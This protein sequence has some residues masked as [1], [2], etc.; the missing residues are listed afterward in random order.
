M[1]YAAYVKLPD[2]REIM[3][4]ETVRKSKNRVKIAVYKFNELTRAEPVKMLRIVSVDVVEH[5]DNHASS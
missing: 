1:P 3:M 4:L 5:F 2:G